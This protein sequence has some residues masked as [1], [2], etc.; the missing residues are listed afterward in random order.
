M[1]FCVLFRVRWE[2]DEWYDIFKWIPLAVVV[3]TERAVKTGNR[4]AS[5]KAIEIVQERDFSGLDQ[6]ST[7][8]EEN[9]GFH[10]SCEGKTNM[11]C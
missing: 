11:I 4:K 1:E 7:S 2:A 10:I 6:G 8:R 3:K 5:W 9:V